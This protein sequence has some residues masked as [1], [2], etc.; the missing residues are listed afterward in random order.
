[1]D[2]SFS[3]PNILSTI[4]DPKYCERVRKN[5]FGIYHNLTVSLSSSICQD[6]LRNLYD[7]Q[8]LDEDMYIESFL[9]FILDCAEI[10]LHI[11]ID[12][13]FS[14]AIF[15]CTMDDTLSEQFLV[16]KEPDR[17][18]LITGF[19]KAFLSAKEPARWT[20]KFTENVADLIEAML[21]VDNNPRVTCC[22]MFFRKKMC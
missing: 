17:A 8:L 13:S 15:R 12:I 4:S 14:E 10:P 20:E 6:L 21:E 1:M 5:T 18:H 7:L 2:E 16:Y 22:A 9:Q 3:V 19:L 11:T